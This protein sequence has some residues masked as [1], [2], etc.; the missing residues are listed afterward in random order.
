M[1]VIGKTHDSVRAGGRS[2]P[3]RHRRSRGERMELPVVAEAEGQTTQET[4]QETTQETTQ[5]PIQARL[6]AG[7]ESLAIHEVV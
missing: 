2:S 6:R 4:I 3:L 1:N 7:L 5:A